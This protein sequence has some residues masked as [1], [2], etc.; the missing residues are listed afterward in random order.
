MSDEPTHYEVLGVT[1]GATKEQLREAYRVR[2]EQVQSDQAHEQGAKRPNQQALQVAREDQARLQ[3][4]WQ[5]LSDPYQR[6]R[7]DQLLGLPGPGEDGEAL[8][9]LGAG[10]VE[11]MDEPGTDVEPVGGRSRR[12]SRWAELEANRVPVTTDD[13]TV[14]E[15]A[16]SGRRAL[17][18]TLD[19]LTTL[20][21]FFATHGIARSSDVKDSTAAAIAAGVLAVMIFVY[22][23]LPT[24][25]AGQTLG[26][27]MTYIMVVDRATGQLPTTNRVMMR[28]GV[29]GLLAA[30][31]P[32]LFGPV[33]VMSGYSFAMS[34]DGLSLLDR[35]GKTAVVV[36]RYKPARQYR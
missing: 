21:L 4:A 5:V 6:G 31:L 32:T 2:T 10:D 28:Y 11:V 25:R 9:E 3:R 34:R 7:Y 22:W 20:A 17:A 33:A 19:V 30:G 29:P 8:G 16:P 23:V 15:L 35:L 27:R 36:A 14:L 24:V 18:A 1:R 12:R 26:K 13:G